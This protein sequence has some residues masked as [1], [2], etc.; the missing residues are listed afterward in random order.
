MRNG[1]YTK[2]KNAFYKKRYNKKKRKDA[3]I[4]VQKNQLVHFKGI[5]WPDRIRTYLR[6]NSLPVPFGPTTD[7][8]ASWTIK[9]NS[10]L[11]I[12]GVSSSN[13]VGFTDYANM[14]NQY[15]VLG[16]K[17]TLFAENLTNQQYRVTMGVTNTEDPQTYNFLVSN[18]SRDM[19]V[20]KYDAFVAHR[21]STEKMLGSNAIVPFKMIRYYNFANIVGNRYHLLNDDTYAANTGSGNLA[22]ANPSNLIFFHACVASLDDNNFAT[23]SDVNVRLLIKFY[24]QFDHPNAPSS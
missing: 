1:K 16:A 6:F 4:K 9:L 19:T 5:Q 18:T 20:A 12:D 10:F 13:I 2:W 24:V 17:V 23:T 15:R 7:P 21:N 11:N 14:Y 3:M 22:L 8:A